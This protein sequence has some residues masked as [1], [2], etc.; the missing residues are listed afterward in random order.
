M[1]YSLSW[2]AT[3]GLV[4]DTVYSRLRL[5]TA[6]DPARR[7]ENHIQS[8][9]QPDGWH[10]VLLKPAEHPLLK[11]SY[12]TALSEGCTALACNV[13][14][15][16]MFSSAEQ[17][18]NGQRLWRLRHQGDIDVHNLEVLGNPPGIL[19]KIEEDCRNRQA[20]DA[21]QPPVDFIFEIPLLVAKS[22][23]TFKHDESDWE[24]FETSQWQ[25]SRPWWRFW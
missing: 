21:E 22:I 25:R 16:V 5:S 12:L 18:T 13:E 17:W 20:T 11:A 24:G 7:R 4:K 1:G 3:K 19:S 15:H 8:L 14:E 6:S 2:I 23:A 10:L 9:D